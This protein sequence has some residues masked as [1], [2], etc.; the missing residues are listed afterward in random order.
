MRVHAP[1]PL[2]LTVGDCAGVGP[3][4]ILRAACEIAHEGPI[5]AYGHADTLQA[6]FESLRTVCDPEELVAGICA[7]SGPADAADLK[8][9]VLAVVDV[10]TAVLI[11]SPYP[12]GGRVPEFGQLQ[13]DA[14][15]V[16]VED[17]LAGRVA[18]IVTAPWHKA[19]LAD[20]NLP[21]TGHTEVLAAC[22][23]TP[24]AV[25]MLAGD[26]LRVAL[27]TVHVPLADVPR[28]L[29]S[30]RIASVAETMAAALRVD[31]GIASPRIALCGLNPHAGEEGHIGDEEACLIVPALAML[32]MR[33]VD[34]VGPYPADTLF[35]R[36]AHGHLR[37]DGIVAMYH[38]Q[39][40]GPLKTF[41]FGEAANV[42]LGLPIVRTSVDH[43]T[44]YDIAGQGRVST[45]SF[46]YA[47]R[48]ARQIA[49]RRSA[50]T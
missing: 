2:A 36:V 41:H 29:D 46:V 30:K 18:G 26:V 13:H 42:T 25:M 22:T 45:S 44:A 50:K 20:V 48:M 14:V 35:P 1:A 31:Y 43:G 6:A 47:A 16:A 12:W 4:L 21:V 38:D 7:V 33:G 8:A 11:A 37:A 27:A 32:T 10:G 24:D 3:E 28:H 19:R 17:A 39:G 49:E 40:L 9:G 15:T 5:V 34:V 23:D